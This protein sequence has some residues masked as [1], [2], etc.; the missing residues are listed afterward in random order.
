MVYFM[1]VGFLANSVHTFYLIDKYTF[2]A[3]RGI[4]PSH[5]GSG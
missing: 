1:Q 5:R 4:V 2:R 3:L